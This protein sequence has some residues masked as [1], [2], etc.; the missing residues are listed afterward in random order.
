MKTQTEF[1]FDQII[2]QIFSKF[3][4]EDRENWRKYWKYV[5]NNLN[6]IIYMNKLC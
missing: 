2:T 1:T 5:Q 3:A 6:L 4:K